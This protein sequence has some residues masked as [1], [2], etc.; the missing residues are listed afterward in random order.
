MWQSSTHTNETLGSPSLSLKE[1]EA[2]SAEGRSPAGAT[3]QGG[4]E[5]LAEGQGLH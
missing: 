3:N 1:G 4:A 2:D 5:G